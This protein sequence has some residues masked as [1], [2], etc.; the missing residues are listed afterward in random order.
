[1]FVVNEGKDLGLVN[2]DDLE[3]EV[4]DEVTDASLGHDRN[5]DSVLDLIDEGGIG[6]VGDTALGTDVGGYALQGQIGFLGDAGLLKCHNVFDHTTVEHL[7]LGSTRV[8]AAEPYTITTTLSS[9]PS[10]AF[11]SSSH[12]GI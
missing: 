4:F 10:L 6:H 9:I 1:V 8:V 12:S 7:G 3:N 11:S 2:A 5:G